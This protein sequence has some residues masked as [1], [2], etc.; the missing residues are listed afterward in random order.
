[1]TMACDFDDPVSDF[2]DAAYLA[3]YFMCPVEDSPSIA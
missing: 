1:M 3:G 2:E